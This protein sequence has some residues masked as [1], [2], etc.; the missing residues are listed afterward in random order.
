MKKVITFD[1]WDTLIKRKCHPEEVKLYT[2]KYIL[3]NYRNDLNHNFRDIYEILLLRNK[4]EDEENKRHLKEG[5]EAE[6]YIGD[7]LKELQNI[8]FKNKP[9][10]PEEY[11]NWIEIE[12]ER[13]K[14]MIFV[15]EDIYEIIEKYKTHDKYCV[16]D[17]YMN[18]KQLNE[19]LKHV[20]LSKYFKKI[21]SSADYFL[22]KRSG[23]LFKKFAID[24][25]TEFSNQIHVG[26]NQY[27]DIEMAQSFGI[28]TIKISKEDIKYETK[29]NREYNFDTDIAKKKG[30][31]EEV[32]LYN[33]GIDFSP[34]L[35]FFV[36]N[37]IEQAIYSKHDKIFYQTREGET[38]I[39]AH[40]MIRSN[41][42]LKIPTSKLLEVSRRSTFAASLN[43]FSIG[44]M[45]RLW[46]QYRSMTMK[47]LYTTLNIDIKKYSLYFKK[48][49]I[50]VEELIIE[51]WFNI[52]VINLFNDKEFLLK[53][54]E[55][56]KKKK[57]SLIEYFNK[58]KI[59]KNNSIFLVDVGWR[60]TIQDNISYIF[61]ETNFL[62]YY[63]AL[64]D[65]Y[66]YQPDNT[67][68]IS[69]IKER[70]FAYEYI[71]PLV[72]FFEILF[73]T[74]SGSVKEYAKGLAI[75][76]GKDKEKE[77]VAR[78]TK[79]I[80]DGMLAGSKIID[81]YLNIHPYEMSEFNNLVE[82]IIVKIKRN[83]SKILA[84][85]YYALVYNET[86]GVG[87]YI[88]KEGKLK[89]SDRISLTKIRKNLRSEMWKEAYLVNY[90]LRFVKYVLKGKSTLRLIKNKIKR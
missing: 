16:S 77:Y 8:I 43:E 66:N 65:F 79:H 3:Y 32:E 69:Y 12:L 68:K 37:G 52:K 38:F 27:S 62:G 72:T 13:E 6:N 45:M 4:I 44:E 55:E 34:L 9:E 60:G 76:K 75:R 36:A 84:K 57:N 28:E 41:S 61:P 26:D 18:S 87:E 5:L 54:N 85:A 80:Q 31:S 7:V 51:P 73:N 14:E 46:S 47:S 50:D 30:N 22:T 81:D 24:T 53:M 86:F 1:I 42:S 19:L 15:N 10:N 88:K 89:F 82:N 40:E 90:D 25:K 78:Y 35:Y 59:V 58:E 67:E 70:E 48:H 20:G 2:A 63:Y 23:G 29:R 71:A 56:L 21:Y 11:K 39:K 64:F 33:L 17:F 74:D 49:D 83:P